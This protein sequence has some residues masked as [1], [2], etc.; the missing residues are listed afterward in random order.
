V[1]RDGKA[2]IET[3]PGAGYITSKIPAEFSGASKATLACRPAEIDF[4][5]EDKGEI[6]GVV[7][8]TAYL[9]ETVDYI[10]KIGDQE[11][12]VQKG[13]REPRYNVGDTCWL[14]FSRVTWYE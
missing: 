10:I 5:G 2:V 9:G 7:D 11:I 12:R 14:D 8:R 6:K 3:A 4:V 13:R 1:V